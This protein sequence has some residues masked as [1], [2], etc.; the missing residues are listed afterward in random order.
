MMKLML[1]FTCT[2]F[3]LTIT[4]VAGQTTSVMSYNIRLDVAS[5]GENA[6]PFRKDFVVDQLKFYS[7]DIFGIQEGTPQQTAYLAAQLDNYTFIGVGRDGGDKGEYSAIFY[8]SIEFSVAE[9]NTFWLSE[10]PTE[11]SMGWDAACNRVCTYGLFTNKDTK[12]K[13]W[14]FNTHLDHKGAIARAKGVQLIL[15]KIKEVNTKDYPVVLTGDFNLEP[16]DEVIATVKNVLSDAKEVAH[17]SFG[18]EGT[19]NAFKFTTAVKRRIDYIFIARTTIK[20]N[21][22]AVLSDSK[23]LK[24]PSD[25]LPVYIEFEIK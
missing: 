18:P 10:T 12:Q 15:N 2:L 8:N 16:T 25:H 4:S 5:D 3:G 21:K 6:W 23:E 13:F 19:F 14:V 9:E 20:V 22:Y 24:Y 11:V 7:P 1:F 17:L